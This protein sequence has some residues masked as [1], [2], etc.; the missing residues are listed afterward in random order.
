[1]PPSHTA[2][3]VSS[4]TGHSHRP[5]QLACQGALALQRPSDVLLKPT[6]ERPPAVAALA[7][8]AP[9]VQGARASELLHA[10]Q[11][12]PA[13][14]TTNGRGGERAAPRSLTHDDARLTLSTRT[15]RPAAHVHPAQVPA[16][17]FADD[18]RGEM[19]S[20]RAAP[21]PPADGRKVRRAAGRPHASSAHPP[22][23]RHHHQP[24]D[25]PTD[26]PQRAR[27]P[28]RRVRL[29]MAGVCSREG[30]KGRGS[31]RRLGSTLISRLSP[32]RERERAAACIVMSRASTREARQDGRGRNRL[33]TGVR[34]SVQ[35]GWGSV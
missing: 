18:P 11:A 23:R 16:L 3:H 30:G 10:S 27:R 1:M 2:R 12:L 17:T 31:L 21:A 6:S 9:V 5:L 35:S 19:R 24:T 25:Q 15:R 29:G 22:T 33:Y 4:R 32:G 13:R 28:A 7:R 8:P 20:R 26:Q 34:G 14:G